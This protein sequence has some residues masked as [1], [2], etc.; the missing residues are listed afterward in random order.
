MIPTDNRNPITPRHLIPSHLPHRTPLGSRSRD[1]VANLTH[2]IRSST[3]KNPDSTQCVLGTLGTV[4]LHPS[5][6]LQPS[7]HRHQP[8]GS[9]IDSSRTFSEIPLLLP[10]FFNFYHIPSPSPSTIPHHS[11]APN[12]QKTQ[13]STNSLSPTAPRTWP[14]RG[15]SRRPPHLISHTHLASHP[16]SRQPNPEGRVTHHHPEPRPRPHPRTDN[17]QPR[18]VSATTKNPRCNSSVITVCV[19]PNYDGYDGCGVLGRIIRDTASCPDRN[20]DNHFLKLELK[21]RA[22]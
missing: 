4:A 7:S 11:S 6:R 13:H 12:P 19:Y 15:T 22:A 5:S 17:P 18:Q 16:P 8:H 9:R 20:L 1:K 14:T 2:P 10:H 21:G 3:P